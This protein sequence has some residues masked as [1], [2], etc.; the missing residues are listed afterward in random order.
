MPFLFVQ[1]YDL[2]ASSL[3]L[4]DFLY[5]YLNHQVLLKNWR[6][7]LY[8][9]SMTFLLPPSMS[10]CCAV[11]PLTHATHVDIVPHWDLCPSCVAR[12]EGKRWR[13]K[14][15][16]KGREGV[17]KGTQWQAWHVVHAKSR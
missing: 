8:H 13:G 15:G 4:G 2:D 7:Y 10:T 17:S 5:I 16:G 14:E 11:S 12:T 9:I 1:K 6:L 3:K